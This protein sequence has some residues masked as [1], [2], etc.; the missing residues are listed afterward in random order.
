M[1]LLLK[2]FL[3]VEAEYELSNKEIAKAKEEKINQTTIAENEALIA[4]YERIP[5]RR[6]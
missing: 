5:V 4:E 2:K 1:N 6:S 3:K